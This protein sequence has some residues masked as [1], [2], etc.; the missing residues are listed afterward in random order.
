M[1]SAIAAG[2]RGLRGQQHLKLTAGDD[3]GSSESSGGS[4]GTGSSSG[5]FGDATAS[6]RSSAALEASGSNSGGF[7]A[8]AARH[9][10]PRRLLLRPTRAGAAPRAS[11]GGEQQRAGASPTGITCQGDNTVDCPSAAAACSPRLA[12]RHRGACA[13][14]SRLRVV[15]VPGTGTC[16]GNVGTACN[17]TGTGKV[18]NNCNPAEGEG[19]NGST[20]TCTGDCANVGS[21]YIGCEYYAITMPNSLLPQGTFPFAVSVQNT[22]PTQARDHHDRTGP[23]FLPPLR[24][25]F[26]RVASLSTSFR[27]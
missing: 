16:A 11:D 17:S 23:N 26:R 7:D 24:R 13:N 15:C 20:G 27:G 2:V 4:S 9:R 14:W 22:S 3:G 6:F 10:V 5:S 1:G 12:A 25:R 19:C 18:T 8:L 21:S